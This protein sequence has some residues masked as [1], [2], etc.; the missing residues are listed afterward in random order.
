VVDGAADLGRGWQRSD[1]GEGADEVVVLDHRGLRR[2]VDLGGLAEQAMEVLVEGSARR[3]S[4][5]SQT[6]TGHVRL[7]SRVS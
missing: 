2:Q 3:D 4:A 5:T 7:L 1:A 6:L